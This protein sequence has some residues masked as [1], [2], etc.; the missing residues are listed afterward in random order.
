[1]EGNMKSML[2]GGAAAVALAS[3]GVA[4]VREI[5]SGRRLPKTSRLGPKKTPSGAG[6]TR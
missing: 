2:V 5:R 3:S 6:A 4:S 1:M